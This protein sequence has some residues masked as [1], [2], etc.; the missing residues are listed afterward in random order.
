MSMRGHGPHLLV[1]TLQPDAQAL[2]AAPPT[3]ALVR[4]LITPG[5]AVA[6]QG[7]HAMA[8]LASEGIP[9]RQCASVTSSSGGVGRRE[10]AQQLVGWVWVEARWVRSPCP[11]SSR[12]AGTLS[13]LTTLW[14][15]QLDIAA[16]RDQKARRSAVALERSSLRG[17]EVRGCVRC[18]SEPAGVCPTCLV[19]LLKLMRKHWHDCCC[20]LHLP[21]LIVAR[22]VSA[23]A[24]QF[25][26]R[27][28]GVASGACTACFPVPWHAL[29]GFSACGSA[30][31]AA[32]P[33][34]I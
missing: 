8:S 21:L 2:G 18:T 10:R 1:L 22:S 30:S 29:Y 20:C 19:C 27:H 13:S 4:V 15:I 12:L 31:C 17:L 6:C 25:C 32:W 9:P 5:T 11:A 28:V 26:M 23:S 34:L 33:S 24:Q 14:H 16:W 3:S 7:A